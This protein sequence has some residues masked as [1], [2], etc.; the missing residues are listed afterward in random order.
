MHP[1]II[2]KNLDTEL[3]VLPISSKKP[4]EYQKIEEQYMQQ[5]ISLE[6][7]IKQKNNITEIVQ[8]NHIYGFKDITRWSKITRMKKVSILRLNFNGSIGSISGK[9]MNNISQK[10]HLEF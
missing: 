10:I 5:K 8:L 9:E 7:Y 4:I 6:D 3:F 1:A 2:L